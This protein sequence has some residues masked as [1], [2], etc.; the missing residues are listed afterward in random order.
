MEELRFKYKQNKNNEII[1]T[2][3]KTKNA[4]RIDIPTEIDGKTVVSIAKGAFS[5]KDTV[6]IVTVPNTITFIG[7]DAFWGMTRLDILI[8]Y[9][10][11]DEI[12]RE[13]VA[14]CPNLKKFIIPETVKKIGA[15][16]FTGNYSLQN[17]VIPHGVEIIEEF[18]FDN[19][20]SITEIHFPSSVKSMG[21]AVVSG[22]SGLKSITCYDTTE[23][24][25]VTFSNRDKEILTIRSEK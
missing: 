8:M 20:K 14:H 22:C 18:A 7:R 10:K 21:N 15:F 2:G 16:A 6:K 12:P 23:L 5:Q 17:M 24:T 13:M 11:I 3:L 25:R 1:I 4:T 9:A 19:C